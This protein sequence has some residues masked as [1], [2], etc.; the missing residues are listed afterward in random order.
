M[1]MEVD[2]SGSC[3]EEDLQ[4]FDV[5]VSGH[6]TEEKHKHG[7]I[8]KPFQKPPLGNREKDFYKQVFE[9]NPRKEEY[10]NIL[11]NFLPKFYGVAQIIKRNSSSNNG[12][13]NGVAPKY[14]VMENILQGF[15]KPCAIDLKIGS[16]TWSPD[17]TEAKIQQERNFGKS[18]DITTINGA[19]KEFFNAE[20]SPLY[21]NLV[22]IVYDKLLEIEK[23][24]DVQKEFKIYGS[25]VLIAY[26]A[27]YFLRH[28]ENDSAISRSSIPLRVY[29]IDFAHVHPSEDGKL[30][31]NYLF[32]LKNLI[33]IFKEILDES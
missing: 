9:K 1:D 15:N 28:S 19:V 8:L 6:G 7:Y 27:E 32:G 33:R 21:R 31:E 4:F 22:K 3:A 24:F 20:N 16:Q 25:S 14:L 18:L 13:E 23:V 2:R 10:Y 12:N 26:D 11:E 29:L 30:D 5:Q 17:A